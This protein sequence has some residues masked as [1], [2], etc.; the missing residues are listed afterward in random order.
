MAT[1]KTVGR[2]KPAH[3]A[4]NDEAAALVLRYKKAIDVVYDT[5]H[6]LKELGLV[7]GHQQKETPEGRAVVQQWTLQVAINDGAELDA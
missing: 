6:R 2:R 1:K 5:Q 7:I 3:P 4:L